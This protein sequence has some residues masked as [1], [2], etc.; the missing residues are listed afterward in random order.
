MSASGL[1]PRWQCANR[2]SYY[3][4][5]NKLDQCCVSKTEGGRVSPHR[6]FVLFHVVVFQRGGNVMYV[7]FESFNGIMRS[8]LPVPKEPF[9]VF[10]PFLGA[11]PGLFDV[12]TS[13]PM[14]GHGTG[15]HSGRTRC[16][17]CTTAPIS[18]SISQS[19]GSFD[20]YVSCS[21]R[22]F[23]A[24]RCGP[25]SRYQPRLVHTDAHGRRHRFS[26]CQGLVV[27]PGTCFFP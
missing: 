17:L 15:W 18:E 22:R 27:T 19:E 11:N 2:R 21:S 24:R 13:S 16:A 7:V 5:C 12:L 10:S 26:L 14:P 4:D 6:C 8:P 9:N 1:S 25:L 23:L 3:C 20:W